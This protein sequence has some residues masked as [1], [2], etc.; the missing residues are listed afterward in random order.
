[1]KISF[2]IKTLEVT[3]GR[4]SKM[5]NVDCDLM[6]EGHCMKISRFQA[7]INLLSNG[8]FMIYNCGTSRIKVDGEWIDGEKASELRHCS[9]LEF[10]DL[11]FVFKIN[12]YLVCSELGLRNL[13]RK[14]FVPKIKIKN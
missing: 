4:N 6:L 11:C 10:D 5:H 8:K 12:Y 7:I 1:M 14:V 3:I 2:Q 9:F 13:D